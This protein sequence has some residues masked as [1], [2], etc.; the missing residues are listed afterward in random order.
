MFRQ[1]RD[2]V[3]RLLGHAP[4]LTDLD[5]AREVRRPDPYVWR[6]P[7]PY[8]ARRHRWSRRSRAAGGHL[9]FPCDEPCWRT[10]DAAKPLP[11]HM[12][13]IEDVARPYVLKR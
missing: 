10:P 8:D 11:C 5:L 3:A 13:G 6:L 7:S 12:D 2:A 4:P 9:S 1:L